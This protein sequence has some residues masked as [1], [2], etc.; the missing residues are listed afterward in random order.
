M[1]GTRVQCTLVPEAQTQQQPRASQEVAE[2]L[3]DSRTLGTT[4]WVT[5]QGALLSEESWSQKIT[6]VSFRL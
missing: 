2:E 6:A 5:L 4:T 1:F 3:W